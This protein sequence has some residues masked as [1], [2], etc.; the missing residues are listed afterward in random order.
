MDLDMLV[1]EADPAH[2][3][4]PVV[5]QSDVAQDLLRQI[6]AGETGN[7]G[8]PRHNR[9]DRLPSGAIVQHSWSRSPLV[10]VA[11]AVVLLAAGL[12]AVAISQG[13]RSTRS[14]AL[15]PNP[16]V[17]PVAMNWRLVSEISPQIHPFVSTSGSPQGLHSLTCPSARVC[18]LISSSLSGLPP[19]ALYRSSDGGGTWLPMKLPPGV[20]LD[21]SLSCVSETDC[22]VGAEDGLASGVDGSN[23]PQVLLSTQDGGA[24]WVTHDVPMPSI[25]GADTAL[26]QTISSLEGHLSDLQCFTAS[27][28]I[29]FGTTPADQQAQPINESPP[30]PVSQTV[31]MRTN[32]GG[33]TWATHVFPWST[34]PSGSPGW[35]NEQVATFSCETDQ[36]CVGLATVL[37]APNTDR[38]SSSYGDQ[39]AYLLEYRSTDGG[40]SWTNN[41]VPDTQGRADSL[42][43]PDESNCIAV[44]EFG[45]MGAYGAYGVLTS[46][47]GGATWTE[48]QPFPT[49]NPGWNGITSITCPTS[50]SCWISGSEQSTSHPS[51]P[52]GAM[53]TTQDGGHTWL[54]VE[55]PGGLGSVNQVACPTVQSCLAIGQ[56][57]IPNGTVTSRA[58]NP[59]LVLTNQS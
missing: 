25:K 23:V 49:L 5:A 15:K 19:N 3:F 29:A 22:K 21:T 50:T 18:Y 55:L 1:R 34:T 35:S 10:A 28:C 46:T 47:D 31:A 37:A 7:R 44:T 53:F 14:V 59:T 30:D 4:D 45:A 56:P 2:D 16:N 38:K 36:T 32:D 39:A 9:H 6:L 48:E 57:P 58:P 8:R 13:H 17:K 43:C 52:Q 54:P 41:W 42:S 11:A 20:F 33:A 27:S 26:D 40:V 24:S 51:D 12:G